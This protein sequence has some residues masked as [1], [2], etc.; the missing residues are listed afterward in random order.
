MK[1]KKKK[2]PARHW[3]WENIPD[4]AANA[5]S[6]RGIWPV[7]GIKRR[8]EWLECDEQ[9]KRVT[10]DEPVEIDRAKAFRAE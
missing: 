1:K 5:K 8:P 7:Q 2:K 10:G 3:Y 9:S 4:R 6:W